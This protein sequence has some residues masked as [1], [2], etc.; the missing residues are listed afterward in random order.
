MSESILAR[1]AALDAEAACCED[2]AHK[3]N[4][5]FGLGVGGGL[6]GMAVA[7]P[8]IRKAL[9]LYKARHNR[10]QAKEA[11]IASE[12]ILSAAGYARTIIEIVCKSA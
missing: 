5:P 1:A 10:R 9:L 12:G 4:V 11:R 8:R 2:E 3:I 6:I 7:E